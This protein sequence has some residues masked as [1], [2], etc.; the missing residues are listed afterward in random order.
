MKTSKIIRFAVAVVLF[1]AGCIGLLA[2]SHL[3]VLFLCFPAIILNW[4]EYTRP[5]SRREFW[6]GIVILAIL[7][8]VAILGRLFIPD[9]AV[10]HVMTHPAFV[11]PF[12][13]L[14]MFGLIWR[15]RRDKK[16]ADVSSAVH[17]SK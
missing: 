1:S 9:S 14:L 8:T 5:V 12:W 17:D 2:H 13:I 10:E 15:W 7:V 6:V 3:C 4:R 16:S 11:F